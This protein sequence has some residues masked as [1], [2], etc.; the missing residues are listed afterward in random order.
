MSVAI[1]TAILEDREF[2]SSFLAYCR[3]FLANGYKFTTAALEDAKI[4]YRKGGNAG[5]FVYL[6]LSSWLPKDNKSGREKE[7]ALAQRFVDHG[8][9][10]HPGEEHSEVAGWFRLVFASL[11]QEELTEGLRR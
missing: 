8:V 6:D 2:H 1:A 5:L 4:P 10:L 9:F 11:T 3:S 7:F